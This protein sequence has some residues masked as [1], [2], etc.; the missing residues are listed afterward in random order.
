[1]IPMRSFFMERCPGEEKVAPETMHP[2]AK[3]GKPASAGKPRGR[4]RSRQWVAP[5]RRVELADL[6]FQFGQPQQRRGVVG[7]QLQRLLEK[8]G[9]PGIVIC[10]PAQITETITPPGLLRLRL[11]QHPPAALCLLVVAVDVVEP[12]QFRHAIEG[13][14]CVA[15]SRQNIPPTTNWL[16]GGL[17]RY[18][19]HDAGLASASKPVWDAL[20]PTFCGSAGLEPKLS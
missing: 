3:R 5:P 7:R 6:E 8:R 20:D 15:Y 19:V 14:A 9:G 1:M 10:R 4:D 16:R 13:V 2:A 18:A 11:V 17:C 12:S